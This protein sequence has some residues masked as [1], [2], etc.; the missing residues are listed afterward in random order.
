VDRVIPVIGATQTD[1]LI[2]RKERQISINLVRKN[3]IQ[4]ITMLQMPV[5]GAAIATT[6]AIVA[7]INAGDRPRLRG[8]AGDGNIVP[9]TGCL[10]RN[11][12]A[13]RPALHAPESI[14]AKR[15]NR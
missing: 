4:T 11:R 13:R 10:R 3:V 15:V 14:H 5:P 9:E 1:G 6:K 8:G 2:S 12:C 7:P